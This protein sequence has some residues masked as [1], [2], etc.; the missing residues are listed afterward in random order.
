[1]S[2]IPL[3]PLITES[4]ATERRLQ[5]A[6]AK[7][8][9]EAAKPSSVR[10]STVFDDKNPADSYPE[11]TEINFGETAPLDMGGIPDLFDPAAVTGDGI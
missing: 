1:M 4:R 11:G 7:K 9:K 2:P 8:K 3:N 6:A 5:E 10:M